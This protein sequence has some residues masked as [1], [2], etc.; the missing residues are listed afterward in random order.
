MEIKVVQADVAAFACDAV[1][2]NLFEGVKSPGGATG[3]VDKALGG[4]ITQL[5]QSGELTGKLCE[6]RLIHTF[7]KIPASRVI[8]VGLGKSD[9]FGLDEVRRVAAASLK[10]ARSAK[11]RKVA[12]I[13]HGA[14]IGGLD[15]VAAARA[16]TEGVLL[17]LYRFKKYFTDNKEDSAEVESLTVLEQEGPK[18]PAIQEGVRIGRILAEATNMARDMINE[19][20]NVMTP[21]RMAEIAQDAAKEHGLEFTVLDKEKMWELGMGSLLSVARGSVEPPKLIVLRYHGAGAQ[22]SRPPLA[23]VGKGIT[24][25]SGG[26]SIKPS[27]R[28]EEMKGDMSGGAAVICAMKAIA[29]LKPKINVIGIVPAT[30]NLPSG[31]ATK[32]GDVVRAM[33]GKTIEV[34]N[35]DAEGRLILA[36]AVAYA[37]KLGGSPI[38]DVATLTGACAVAIGPFYSGLL[39]TDRSLIEAILRSAETAGE[40]VWELPLTD[41]YQDLVKS[42]VADIKNVG[43]RYGGA[44]T[45]AI[46]IKLFADDTPWAHLDI[47]PT[48]YG[49]KEEGYLPKGGRGIMVRTF[50]HLAERLAT[51]G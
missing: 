28:M 49:D 6:T 17:G 20:A 51:Q 14:G 27:E 47:A 12:T 40:K 16:L 50:V 33:N 22:G 5:I 38:V 31:S 10:V 13:V 25:D 48:F 9:K 32:P 18:H 8:V 46:F 30:E 3:A 41:D 45:G 44:I 4:W 26:I 2:V 39:G 21:T 34:I 43:G 24:F 11:A 15:T 37:R 7:G 36:D 42:D 19:P 35:T 1:V 29:Q 23:L